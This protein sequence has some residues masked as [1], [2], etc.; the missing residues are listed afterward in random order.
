MSKIQKMNVMN[1]MTEENVMNE[2]LLS[3]KNLSA[4]YSKKIVVSDL[5]FDLQEGEIVTLIGPNGSGK[6]TVLK[7]ITKQLAAIFGSVAVCSKNLEAIRGSELSKAI[8]VVSTEK[9][10]TNF[11]T[12][13][14]V[15]ESGRYPHTNVFWHAHK[16]RP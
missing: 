15:I 6:S 1:L 7:T 4:G 14:E 11:M 3:V 5:N 12:C 2:N 8:S 9:P 13:R 10:R 16:R